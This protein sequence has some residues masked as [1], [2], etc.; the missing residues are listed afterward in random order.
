MTSLCLFVV[1]LA[2][3]GLSYYNHADSVRTAVSSMHARY[4]DLAGPHGGSVRVD[5]HY[6]GHGATL[7]FVYF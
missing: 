7:Y 5:S 2:A 1:I 4:S 3:T 6:L